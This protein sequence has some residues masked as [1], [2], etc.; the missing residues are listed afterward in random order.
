MAD[1][2]SQA[3]L[4]WP[5]PAARPGRAADRGRRTVGQLAEPYQVSVQA[6]SKHLKVLEQAGLVSRPPRAAPQP[7]APGGGGL[8]PDDEWIER[9][10]RRA[11]AALPAAGRRAGGTG[12][13]ERPQDDQESGMNDTMHERSRPTR[14]SRSS[15]SPA[16]S[17]PRP[18]QLFR[19]HT[20]PELFARWVGPDR[21][22]TTVD[23]WDATHRR[24]LALRRRARRDGVRLPRLLPRGPA[25]PHRADL[26][27]G[28]RPGRGRPRDADLRG[29]GR[30][31]D[32][33]AR[34][35]AV[36]QLREPGRAAAQR[37]GGRRRPGLRQARRPAG[38]RRGARREPPR[39]PR[40]APP[41][42]GRGLHRPRAGGVRLGRPG[43]GARL[44]RP[45]RRRSP[46]RVVPC[47]PRRARPAWC[48]TAG[49]RWRTTRSPPGRCTPTR[50]SGCSTA[51]RRPT[52]FRHPMVG[53]M[54]LPVAVDRFY[55]SDVFMHTWDLARAT[56]QDERLDPQTCADL[57]A[58]MEPIEELMR[59]S[60]Q[61]GPAVPVPTTP[62]SRPG[63]WPSSAATR[64]PAR[65]DAAQP[66]NLRRAANRTAGRYECGSRRVGRV[67]GGGLRR[68]RRRDVRRRTH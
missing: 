60:G 47:V 27:L 51:R 19:A 35:V 24:Q 26:H 68:S 28:G 61:Y 66:P 25:G 8:R 59:S 4:H 40:R 3:S 18:A 56:G 46:R 34:A 45:R 23:R 44:A 16:T 13:R 21:M 39:R 57:L 64:W 43:P 11:E 9:Y 37:H 53:E 36:R 54:P 17:R 33:A 31:P 52:A 30:R 15:A 41:R 42:R 6:I 29:P 7:G 48:S 62:T 49:R 63:C 32:A 50:C 1:P 20:D 14:R 38:D 2:L 65:T 22:T 5:T 58:G 12:R 10:R 67:D 55:T